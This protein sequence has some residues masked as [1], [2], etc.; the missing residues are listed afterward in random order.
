[1]TPAE[2][3][4][5]A[6]KM[7]ALKRQR[8]E[9]R[10]RVQAECRAWCSDAWAK[11]KDADNQNPYLQRKGVH[12]Y[13]LKSFNDTLL[14][15]VMDMA[16]TIHGL[17][18][19][20]PDGSKKF[21]TGTNKT[22]HF[23]KIGKSKDKTVLICEGYATGASIY[24]ATGH[25]VVVA[26]DAG[27]LKPVAET[28]RAKYPDCKIIICAD[29]DYGTE[30]NPGLTKARAAAQ[31]IGGKLA[32]PVF[33]DT[34]TRGT[35]FNDLHQ[36]DGLEAVQACIEEATRPETV[37]IDQPEVWPEPLVFG[38]IE[39]PEI[40]STLLSGFLAE[41]CNAVIKATQ[42]P[43][44][45]AVMFALSTVAACLQKR[46]EV[47]PFQDDYTEPLSLWTVTALDP[48]NRKTG[49]KNAITE[50]LVRW[51][52][53]Q[54]ERLKPQI[55]E[56]DHR[57]DINLKRID[58]LKAKAA[59]PETLPSDR[60][61]Y[62]R[63]IV[64]TEND[65]PDKIKEPRLWTDDVTPEQ[66][67]ALMANH[68]ERMALLSDEGGIFEVMAG[69]YTNGRANLNVFLQSHAG[70]PVRVDR[71]G[72]TVTLNKPAL[73]FGLAVQP[74][75]I[76]DLAQGNKSRFRG[77]G[78]LARFLYCIPKSTIGTRD[79]THRAVIPESVRVKYHTGLMALLNL[80]PVCN[81]HGQE[82][83]RIL[84]LNPDA[85][86]AW[87]RFSQYIESK[88]GVDGEFYSFQDWTSK[89][90]G[91]ALRIAGL[92]HIVEHGAAN[93]TINRQTMER[94]LD[95]SDLLISHAR[96]AF[97]LMGADQAVNDAKHVLK[98]IMDQGEGAFTQRDCLKRHE[99]RFKRIDR[100]TKALA[101]LIERHII[102][103]PQQRKTGK[104]PGIYYLVNPSI[105]Q[106]DDNGMA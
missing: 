85:L 14:L 23:F 18:F 39:T 58:Q 22:G 59:K 7:E 30:G 42:T 70:A 35:D 77:N 16:E 12:A 49:V 5:Y 21:K 87:L 61:A 81:E 47:S 54:A 93:P 19:I 71:Q 17:Q 37:K 31:S 48:G 74:D 6:A 46:F 44:G 66:L 104:R 1:M 13:G 29:D 82:Q 68:G 56:V 94:A 65:T 95:L 92:L 55:R 38:P 97:D 51:E 91:A 4:T 89:L 33:Q 27:N 60:E 2:K 15:P 34:S 90:P 41:Y 26:F 103:E 75:I 62:L 43:P 9:E 67:Q 78:T 79:V 3:A 28:I 8:D 88:Q 102:S 106:G 98:W 25:C 32:V 24:Q 63:E 73:S 10:D 76:S 52:H 57:R 45:L 83:A 99:G 69:L 72:R 86:Q 40:P 96:A 84:T 64:Q 100:L 101:V 11:A 80:D 20:S 105:L 36:A 53:E 50:P